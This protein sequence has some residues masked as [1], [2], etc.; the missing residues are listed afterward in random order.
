[1]PVA[2]ADVR[3]IAR[4]ALERRRRYGRG[5]TQVGVARARDIANGRNLSP[6]TLARMR[7]FFARHDTPAERAARARDPMSPAAIAWDLWGGDPARAWIERNPSRKAPKAEQIRG[8]DRNR[9]DSAASSRGRI[10]LSKATDK[11]LRRKVREHN[12]KHGHAKGRRVTLGMLRAVYRRGAGAFSTSHR[13]G[14]TRG[15]WALAR[16]NAFLDLVASG[17]PKD[18]R[19]ISDNDLLPR[20]HRRRS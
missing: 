6:R 10:I 17:A 4:D 2:P 11:A 19:Y 3:E 16:V 13:P 14:M 20:G 1:M 7:S 5:G 9:P 18:P 8:S 12:A 15:R